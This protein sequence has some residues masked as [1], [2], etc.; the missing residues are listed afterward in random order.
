[1]MDFIARHYNRDEFIVKIG[2][3]NKPSLNLFKKLGFE[4]MK[5]VEVF[6]EIHMK[7]IYS[8]SI[9]YDCQNMEIK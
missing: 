4:F 9:E 2:K 8:G 1:M 7:Q 6:E 3:D 5:E